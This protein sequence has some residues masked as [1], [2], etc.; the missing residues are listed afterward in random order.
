MYIYM[1]KKY[2]ISE[3]WYIY[4]YELLLYIY[5]RTRIY[6]QYNKILYACIYRRNVSLILSFH[7]FLQYMCRERESILCL[8]VHRT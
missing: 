4:I 8:Y 7:F 3:G 2:N 1:H 5:I 6:I